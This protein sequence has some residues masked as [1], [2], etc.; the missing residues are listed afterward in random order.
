MRE[1]HRMWNVWNGSQGCDFKARQSLSCRESL[2]VSLC[3]TSTRLPAA[4]SGEWCNLFWE[5]MRKR[6]VVC[7][8]EALELLQPV[9]NEDE[10]LA[11]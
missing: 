10:M 8:D 3:P 6:S 11:R 5:D 2:H 4:R 1:N 7:G 9:L